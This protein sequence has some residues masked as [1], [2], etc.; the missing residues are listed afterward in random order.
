[1][2]VGIRS[3]ASPS[4]HSGVAFLPPAAQGEADRPKI[5]KGTQDVGRSYPEEKNRTWPL[6]ARGR[7]PP[8]SGSAVSQRIGAKL[9]PARTSPA[10][11]DRCV[12]RIRLGGSN[13][14][15]PAWD[16]DRFQTPRTGSIAEA[17]RRA[18]RDR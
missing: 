8:R 4:A 12:S 10:S 13:R 1:M 17:A 5:T 9:P 16:Q 7:G 14:R 3:L 15:R 2:P 6:S 18:S 11:G